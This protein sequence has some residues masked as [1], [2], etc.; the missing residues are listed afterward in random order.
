VRAVPRA[1][2]RLRTISWVRQPGWCEP[3]PHGFAKTAPPGANIS[4]TTGLFTQLRS[5]CSSTNREPLTLDARGPSRPGASG[6]VTREVEELLQLLPI[7]IVAIT[8]YERRS[9]ASRHC[10]ATPWVGNV[11]ELTGQAAGVA[12]GGQDGAPPSMFRR[13]GVNARCLRRGEFRMDRRSR[14]ARREHT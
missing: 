7:Q 2:N 1:P 6:S 3:W 12:F 11:H 10:R 4:S 14:F 13:S 9:P 5:I 8:R